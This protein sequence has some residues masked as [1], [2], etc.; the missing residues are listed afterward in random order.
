M[1]YSTKDF[2]IAKNFYKTHEEKCERFARSIHKL[3]ESRK[4]YDDLRTKKSIVI[5]QEVPDKV[6]ENRHVSNI[7]QATTMSGKS[8]VLKHRVDGFVRN[9][10]TIRIVNLL[11]LV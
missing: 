5:L 6:I 4:K 7:C 11:S 2:E 10:H 8:V 1:Q 3:R 9:I